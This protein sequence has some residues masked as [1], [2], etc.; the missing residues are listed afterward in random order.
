MSVR[1]MSRQDIPSSQS[2]AT[3]ILPGSNGSDSKPLPFPDILPLSQH[4]RGKGRRGR[5]RKNRGQLALLSL[6]DM[7]PAEE[8]Q[9]AG[10]AANIVVAASPMEARRPDK[11]SQRGDGQKNVQSPVPVS[12]PGGLLGEEKNKREMINQA[13]NSLTILRLQTTRMLETTKLR[14][15]VMEADVK[16][17][18]TRYGKGS[19]FEMKLSE[20]IGELWDQVCDLQ[21]RLSLADYLMEYAPLEVDKEITLKDMTVRK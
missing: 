12:A 13:R 4:S 20:R 21:D 11:D 10:K 19:A 7:L 9:D 14:I 5:P 2:V 1:Q 3:D 8:G 17:V 6:F 16:R 15:T 18:I